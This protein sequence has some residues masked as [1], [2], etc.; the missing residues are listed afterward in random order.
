MDVDIVVVNYYFFCVDM[1]VKEIGFGEL[2]FEVELV[3]FDEAY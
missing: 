3:I 2:I 1:V